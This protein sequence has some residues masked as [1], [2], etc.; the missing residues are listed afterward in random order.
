[1]YV[2]IG[3]NGCREH[4]D[5]SQ[6]VVRRDHLVEAKLVK[7]LSLISVLPPHH[8]RISCRFLSRNHCS[9]GSS[10]PFSTASV[11]FGLGRAQL[12]GPLY[13]DERTSSG[14]P[15]MSEKCQERTPAPRDATAG[16]PN[17]LRAVAR[18]FK[19]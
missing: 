4:I 11:I 1:M 10:T 7:E 12:R 18:R 13:L 2:Q 15:G 17:A 5:P 3:Q 8:S 9:L 19:R 16:T 6:Q 14:R